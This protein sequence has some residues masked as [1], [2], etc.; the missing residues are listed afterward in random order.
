MK[1]RRLVMLVLMVG[2][3]SLFTACSENGNGG[4]EVANVIGNNNN[5]DKAEA[6]SRLAEK[7]ANGVL[8]EDVIDDIEYEEYTVCGDTVS[9]VNDVEEYVIVK[10]DIDVE[11]KTDVVT[12]QCDAVSRMNTYKF[13]MEVKYMFDE[14]HWRMDETSIVSEEEGKLPGYLV[15][16][17]EKRIINDLINENYSVGAGFIPFLFS[18]C[19]MLD[20]TITSTEYTDDSY[21]IIYFDTTMELEGNYMILKARAEYSY[22]QIDDT[23]RFSFFF[24]ESQRYIPACAGT[25]TGVASNGDEYT[26]VVT[27]EL[28]ENYY[29][30]G[31]VVIKR[32][33]DVYECNLK[34]QCYYDSDSGTEF[35]FSDI[36]WVKAPV[37]F[38]GVEIY[39]EGR[40]CGDTSEI[41]VGDDWSMTIRKIK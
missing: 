27:E 41:T 15:E 18:E 33:S 6:E 26:I 23:W 22:H 9:F 35:D 21:K 28:D 10:H 8:D 16:I 37:E 17:D 30:D 3:M 20:T 11:A 2:A 13:T 38:T 40:I 19:N 24:A 32:G 7:I 29:S 1:K 36:Q 14:D 25:W 39:L 5:A 31:N 12:I 4:N 34:V